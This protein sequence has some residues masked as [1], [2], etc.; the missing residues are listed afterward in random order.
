MCLSGLLGFS[1]AQGASYVHIPV[2]CGHKEHSSHDVA[3]GDRNE[4][5]DE[6][7]EPT[8]GADEIGRIEIAI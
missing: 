5:G 6:K 4:V 7:V 3:E 8:T 1:S 2:N